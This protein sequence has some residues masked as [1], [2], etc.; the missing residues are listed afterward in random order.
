MRREDFDAWRREPVTQVIFAALAKARDREK[1]EWIR[2]SWDAGHCDPLV[3]AE[4]RAKAEAF[5]DLL[6]NSYEIWMEWSEAE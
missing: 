6:S 5:E 3:L 1:A 4:L 2:Q